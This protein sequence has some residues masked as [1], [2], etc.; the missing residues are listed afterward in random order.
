MGAGPNVRFGSE[1][2][3]YS[4]HVAAAAPLSAEAAT[5]HGNHH[6]RGD[7]LLLRDRLIRI[8]KD[9]AKGVALTSA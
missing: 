7:K 9:H 5:H 3:I 1:A 8:V 2:G 6:R 4:V